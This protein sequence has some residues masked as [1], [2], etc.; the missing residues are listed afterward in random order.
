MPRILLV[1]HGQSEWNAE[2]RWQGQA[3]IALSELGRRQA[4]AAAAKLGAFDLMAS[5]TLLRASE[6]AAILSDELGIGPVLPVPELVERSAGEW[7]GLTRADIDREWPGY[8]AS[9]RRPPSYEHDESLLVR[10]IAGLTIV[11]RHAADPTAE[12]LAVAHG[13]LIY[14]LEGTAGRSHD[15]IPNLGALWLDVDTDGTIEVGERVI[16]IDE[17]ELRSAQSSD[18]L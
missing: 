9:G 13:G 1:R 6:T 14:L 11:A 4:R 18:I 2:G 5:S 8:L 15:R 12:L 3:D 10:T 17:A 16:L 7:S